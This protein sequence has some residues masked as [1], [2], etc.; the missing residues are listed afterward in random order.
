MCPIIAS[1]RLAIEPLLFM[2]H[3][4]KVS[5]SRERPLTG[6]VEAFLDFIGIDP[7]R[8]RDKS[9][10]RTIARDIKRQLRPLT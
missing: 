1:R 7:K 10:V 6:A 2:M 8:R 5:F 4:E 9:G 3:R